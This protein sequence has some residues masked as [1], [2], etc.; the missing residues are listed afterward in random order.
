ML[1]FFI[2]ASNQ[3]TEIS[4]FIS[5]LEIFFSELISYGMALSHLEYLFA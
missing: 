2:I 5:N 1:R 3:F 4:H